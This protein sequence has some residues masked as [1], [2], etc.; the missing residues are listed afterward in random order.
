MMHF[1]CYRNW[2]LLFQYISRTG[3]DNSYQKHIRSFEK[4]NLW[5]AIDFYLILVCSCIFRSWACIGND[6]EGIPFSFSFLYSYAPCISHKCLN[7]LKD[8]NNTLQ[9]QTCCDSASVLRSRVMGFQIA[10]HLSLPCSDGTLEN[11]LEFYE[12]QFSYIKLETITYLFQLLWEF[13][14]SVNNA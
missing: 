3:L 14:F 11:L 2:A 7:N 9:W 5:K 13:S 12:P 6:L 8:K 4:G 1:Y 10:S